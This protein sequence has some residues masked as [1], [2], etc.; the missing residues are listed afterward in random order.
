VELVKAGQVDDAKR[1]LKAAVEHDPQLREAI[2][3][4]PRLSA[5]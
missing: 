5:V 4:H 1:V 2:L 3:D